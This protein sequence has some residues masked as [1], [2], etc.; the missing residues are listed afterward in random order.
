MKATLRR[1]RDLLAKAT[2]YPFVKALEPL[3]VA[4]TQVVGKPY[5]W[6]L[7]D[8]EPHAETLL[9][10]KENVFG[11]IKRFLGGNQKGDSMTR[12]A[13]IW[14]ATVEN[15]SYATPYARQGDLGQSSLIPPASKA[16]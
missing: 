8:L 12:R 4:L 2:R 14:L 9:A 13:S 7:T 5:G 6:Y 11:P 15:L 10:L 1:D 3:H 16:A